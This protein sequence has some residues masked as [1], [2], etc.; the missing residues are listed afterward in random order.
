MTHIEATAERGRSLESLVPTLHKQLY[1]YIQCY[2]P[3]S[4]ELIVGALLLLPRSV[5]STAVL[6][7]NNRP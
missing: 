3:D 1:T 5:P 4:P 6:S 2:S 7:T